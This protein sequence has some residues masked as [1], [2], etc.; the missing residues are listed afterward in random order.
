MS[1]TELSAFEVFPEPRM[2]EEL[3]IKPA[4]KELG[5]LF[6]REAK[7]VAEALEAM[8]ECERLAGLGT[9]WCGVMFVCVFV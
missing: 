5:K 9:V 1:K 6:K 4:M 2:V 8:S 3:S 7:A